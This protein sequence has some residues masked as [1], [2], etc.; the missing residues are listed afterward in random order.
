MY[1]ISCSGPWYLWLP[2]CLPYQITISSSKNAWFCN[3][4][5]KHAYII[6]TIYTYISLKN[7]QNTVKT[8][9]IMI[10]HRKNTKNHEKMRKIYIFWKRKNK[11]WSQLPGCTSRNINWSKTIGGWCGT[12]KQRGVRSI[13]AR[14]LT[15]NYSPCTDSSLNFWE[16]LQ[17][18]WNALMP[19][20]R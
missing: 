10:K 4:K 14:S 9:K 15:A 18:L 11:R 19:Y 13:T 17:L 8:L 7:T 12:W 5:K 6:C 2:Y 3:P 16:Y 20:H 1:F